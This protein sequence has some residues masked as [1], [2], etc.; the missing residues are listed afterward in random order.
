MKILGIDT[1]GKALSVAA[2]EDGR[3]LGELFLD[4]DKKHAQTLVPAI[5]SV[6]EQAGISVREIDVFA[7]AA[8]P[9]SFTGVRIGVATIAAMACAAG[10]P[11]AAVSSLGALARG[12]EEDNLPVCAMMDARRHRCGSKS[13]ISPAKDMPGQPGDRQ[14]DAEQCAPVIC[15]MMDARRHE[16]YAQAVRGAEVVVPARALPLDELLGLLPDGPVLFVG[17]AAVT[18][19]EYIR[20]NSAGSLF[21][22]EGL[23]A[24]RA[25]FV[26]MEAHRMALEGRLVRYDELQPNYLRASQAERLKRER[27]EDA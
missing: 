9:G 21:L 3:L 1:T 12:A 17:D 19:R 23:S 14:A 15:A 2:M 26:C 22:P 6:L 25:S 10:K 4:T 5:H 16:V 18:Y 8:G 27:Q 13:V 11:V 7:C 20:E 24:L